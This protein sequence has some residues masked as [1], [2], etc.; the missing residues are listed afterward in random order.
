MRAQEIAL[1]NRLP[2]VYLVDSGGAFLPLQAEVFPDRDHFGRIFFNQARMSAERIPQIAV[3]DGLVHGRRRLRAGDVRRNDHRQG[4]RHDLPGRPAAREGGDRRRSDGRGARRR[5]RPHAALRRRRLLRRRRRA[6]AAARADDRLHAA[7][8]VKRLP[9]DITAPE[10]PRYDP[11]EIYGIVNADTRKPYDVREIIARLVDGSRFDEFKER[12]GTTLVTGFA[13]LHGFLVGIVANNGVLFSESALKATHFIELCNLRGMPLIFLQ[14]ITGFIVGRQYERG[15][16]AKDGAKMVHAVANSVVPKFTVVIGGSFGAGNY[17]MCGRAYE[18]RLL[19]MWPNA[20]ISVMGGEQAAGVLT[21]VK[22]D[23][24]AREGQH[25]HAPRTK[26]RSAQPILEKYEREGSPYYSTA[27]LWD[28]GILDPA[29]TRQALALGLS[30][31]FNAPIPDAE[32]RRLPDVAIDADA[33]RCSPCLRSSIDRDGSV[34]AAHAEPSRR[35]QRVQRGGDRRADRVGGDGARPTDRDVRAVV[36]AGAGKAFCAGADL[37]GWRR[38][39]PTPQ[40]RTCATPKTSRACSSALDTLPVPVIGRI[41][42]AALGGGAGLAAVCDIVV[43]AEDA[44]FGFTEVKLGILPAVISPFVLAKIGVSAA[45]EL[46][47]TGARFAAA[48][49]QEI[50]LVHEVVP[51][52]ELDDAVERR[53]VESC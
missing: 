2:C 14:N 53:Y 31:A 29:E 39:S 16:I 23:Q 24:L 46:F 48:R 7:T 25:A 35:P 4:H 21:T 45:R 37:A 15:G 5:R 1:E 8:R 51:A 13:R 44:V 49:A 17:G 22:R 20:R 38:R 26:R 9:A 19:W 18:P 27:R 40:A 52:A 47:L 41:Q 3:G 28:D 32:V 34:A 42:G 43:A 11:R 10:E 36:L 6:R 12:Y 30:A 33:R 50:G